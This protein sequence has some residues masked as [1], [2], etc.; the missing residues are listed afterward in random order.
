MK[1]CVLIQNHE[2]QV[3]R[4]Q[5]PNIIHILQFDSGLET[6]DAYSRVCHIFCGSIGITQ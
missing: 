4:L 5:A 6:N 2:K 3:Q 1:V